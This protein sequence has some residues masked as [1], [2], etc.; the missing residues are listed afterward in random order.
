MKALSEKRKKLPKVKEPLQERSRETRRK[1]VEAARELFTE[2]GFEET[3]TH[4]IAERAGVSVGG[5]YA[6]FRNK[7]E[8]FLHILEQ[9]SSEIYQLTRECIETIQKRSMPLSE[10][11]EY[12]FSTMYT[13]HI[14]HGRLNVEMDKFTR[15]NPLAQEIHDSWEGKE[16]EVA[17][18]WLSQ[19]AK[20]AGV[21][22]REAAMVVIGRATHEVFHYLYKNRDRVDEKKVIQS[23]ILMFKRFLRVPD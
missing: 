10:G 13:A 3:T 17:G 11:L 8:L 21:G 7:E 6:H 22:D 4:L 2:M 15:M 1:I 12:Y 16:M 19:Y 14:R 9:R 23:L 20:A 5:L 18:E